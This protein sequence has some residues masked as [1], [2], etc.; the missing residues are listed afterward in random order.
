M[1]LSAVA[2]LAAWLGGGAFVGSL[3][4]FLWSYFVRFGEVAEGTRV[5]RAL[6]ADV[7]LFGAFALHH[8]VL[9]RTRAKQWLASYVPPA[10]ERTLYVWIASVLFVGVCALWQPVPGLLYRHSGL[11]SL[12]HWA[13]V[14]AG[15]WLTLRGTAVMDPLELAGI[16]Q[17]AGQH[18]P[19]RFRVTGPYWMVRH[20]IYL[21]W[22]LIVFGVPVMTGTRLAF[23]AV[24]S[25]YL[26]L[27]IGF[28]ERSLVEAFGQQYRDYQARV[29]WR[30][31]PG[32][33]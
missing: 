15:V 14:A 25:A 4:Y 12:P 27:A 32:V 18:P 13:A 19:S 26:V 5:A 9:A 28:E 10:L 11:G 22:L 17:A 29:R 24:S 21:G 8:S 1:R 16:R 33:W 2:R 3:L 30:L 23:A 7:A 20:P 6:L 31:V